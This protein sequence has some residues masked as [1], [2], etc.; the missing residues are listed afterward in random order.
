[1]G[2]VSRVIKLGGS[3]VWFYYKGPVI[4]MRGQCAL[5]GVEIYVSGGLAGGVAV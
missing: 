1:M 3:I 4:C 2:P 5:R